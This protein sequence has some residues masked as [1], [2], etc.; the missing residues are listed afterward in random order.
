MLTYLLSISTNI[1]DFVNFR[2]NDLAWNIRKRTRNKLRDFKFN[3]DL[4]DDASWSGG[5]KWTQTDLK[6]MRR[7][8]VA[9]QVS[10]NH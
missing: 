1:H 2:H 10:K 8:L 4:R 3:Q 9:A 7:G 6:R 5:G